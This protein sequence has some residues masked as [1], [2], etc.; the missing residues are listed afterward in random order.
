MGFF[1]Y[2]RIMRGSD[3]MH[4]LR[5]AGGGRSATLVSD[6]EYVLKNSVI[7]PWPCRG[8][9]LRRLELKLRYKA[10]WPKAA[11]VLRRIWKGIA[12]VGHR[13]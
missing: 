4:N 13:P 5:H 12:G 11:L 3:A 10:G 1:L 6:A 2:A 7:T 8:D 9:R